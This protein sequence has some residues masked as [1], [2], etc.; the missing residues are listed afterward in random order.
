MTS[1]RLAES[2][3]S[4]SKPLWSP[5][6]QWLAFVR[7]ESR[8]QQDSVWVV[9]PDGSGLR[10]VSDD[11]D[12][13]E[14]TVSGT[15]APNAGIYALVDWSPDGKW[16]SFFYS[17]LKPDDTGQ[18]H[19]WYL[20]DTEQGRSQLIWEAFIPPLLPSWSWDGTRLAVAS[21][22]ERADWRVP[23]A[24]AEIVTFDV[25]STDVQKAASF[26]LPEPF[27]NTFGADALFWGEHNEEIY[28]S[29][30]DTTRQ[31]LRENARTLWRFDVAMNTWEEIAP[32]GIASQT[33]PLANGQGVVSCR[34]RTNGEVSLQ[35][36]SLVE[37][38]ATD[39]TL[40]PNTPCDLLSVLDIGQGSK[41]L[42]SVAPALGDEV[43]IQPIH[44]GSLAQLV[45]NGAILG[46]PADF[47][48]LS[49]SWRPT[50]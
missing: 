1:M 43:W 17:H 16:L 39:L 42:S 14:V 37:Q 34:A 40:Q 24:T 47:R 21:N 50:F 20:I 36:Y 25:G 5:D 49:I 23:S 12:R 18:Q 4:F 35:L 6:G 10:K 11:L 46:F 44:N 15:C 29:L 33:I 27:A 8:T 26:R 41:T 48:I 30:Y 31:P 9:R 22:L 38:T 3:V 28:S 7:S 19:D 32:L 13:Q 45:T 2:E